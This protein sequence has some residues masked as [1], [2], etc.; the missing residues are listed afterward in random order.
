MKMDLNI[1][2]YQMDNLQLLFL[3]KKRGTA[4]CCGG[5]V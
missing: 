4:A 1:G 3:D 5:A 2:L